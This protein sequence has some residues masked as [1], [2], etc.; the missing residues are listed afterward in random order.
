MEFFFTNFG[1]EKRTRKHNYLMAFDAET[2]IFVR[3]WLGLDFKS[4]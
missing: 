2:R 3:C 1:G 4:S